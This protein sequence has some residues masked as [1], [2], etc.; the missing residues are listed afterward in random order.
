MEESPW[1]ISKLLAKDNI[2]HHNFVHVPCQLTKNKT[3]SGQINK[4]SKVGENQV[5]GGF[6]LFVCMKP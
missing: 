2:A 3:N 1:K 5:G 6:I 4:L